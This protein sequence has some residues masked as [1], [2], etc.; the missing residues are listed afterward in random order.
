MVDSRRQDIIDAVDTRLKGILTT[1][2]YET[3][4]GS[5][6]SE[7]RDTDRN[8]LEATELPG[9][10]YRDAVSGRSVGAGIYDNVLR[11]EFEIHADSI[12]TIRKALADVERAVFVDESWGGLADGSD[13]GE[14]ENAKVSHLEDKLFRASDFFEVYFRTVRGNPLT[15]A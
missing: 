8:P 2:G 15:G 6:V 4:L 13:M 14:G 9:I 7:W 11:I 3:S 10:V 5:H 12:A 1:G